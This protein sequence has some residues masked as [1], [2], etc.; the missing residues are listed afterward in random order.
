[1]MSR[2]SGVVINFGSVFASRGWPGVAAYGATKG[3]VVALTRHLAIEYGPAVRV[4]S[5]SPGTTA[6][7]G[8]EAAIRETP[9]PD[10]TRREMAASNRILGRLIEAREVATAALFLASDDSRAVMGH[11]LVVGGGQGVGI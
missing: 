9:D 1:M 5:I 2:G 10:A 8:A 7:P 11:D 3:A 6:T 4:N